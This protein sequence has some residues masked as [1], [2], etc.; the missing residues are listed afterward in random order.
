MI[1]GKTEERKRLE[2]RR[3]Q[4]MDC[5]TD[6]EEVMKLKEELLDCTRYRIFFSG[7]GCGP[8]VSEAA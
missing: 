2:R 4:L 5:L 6:I 1:E 8:V 7:R 3:K